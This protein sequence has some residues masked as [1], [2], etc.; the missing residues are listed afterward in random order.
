MTVTLMG[1]ILSMLVKLT[2]VLF[3]L[4]MTGEPDTVQKDIQKSGVT[5]H[6]K[7]KIMILVQESGPAM[8]STLSLLI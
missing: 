5:V 2:C 4:K 3:K 1:I 7:S 6:S 8:I